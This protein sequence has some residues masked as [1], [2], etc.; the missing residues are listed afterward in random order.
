[1]ACRKPGVVQSMGR[2]GSAPGQRCRSAQL[3]D[4]FRVPALQPGD[5]QYRLGVHLVRPPPGAQA[6][7]VSGQSG[8]QPAHHVGWRAQGHTID[9]GRERSA[10]IG[11]SH[12]RR[13]AD[14][15]LSRSSPTGRDHI[16]THHPQPGRCRP[17]QTHHHSRPADRAPKSTLSI[18]DHQRKRG[19]DTLNR[20]E[21]PSQR[22]VIFESTLPETVPP[23]P[24]TRWVGST[25][26]LGGGIITAAIN[27]GRTVPISPKALRWGSVAT[28]R[29]SID[30]CAFAMKLSQAPNLSPRT[31][32]PIVQAIATGRRFRPR[33]LPGPRSHV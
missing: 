6:F 22:G 26:N 24:A 10:D 23:T 18:P 15:L 5:R 1:M 17:Q 25:F 2:V 9:D 4:R 13:T 7:V 28:A 30:G 12:N 31:P 11:S 19:W 16:V 33:L 32:P 14:L 20:L 8:G 3:D 29:L 27:S 21:H